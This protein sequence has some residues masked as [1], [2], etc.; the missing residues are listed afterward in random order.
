MKMKKTLALLLAVLMMAAMFAGCSEQPKDDSGNGG[1]GTP[2][3][4]DVQPEGGDTGDAD[5][6]TLTV[7]LSP[8]FAPMEFVDVSKSGQDQ[9]VGFDVMLA[10]YIAQEMGLAL[11]IKA[12]SFDACQSAVQLG[13]VDMSI[14]GFSKTDERAENFLLSDFYYAG[15]NETEQTIIVSADKAG[16]FSTAEDFDGLTVAAQTA[17]LQMDLCN[18]QLPD[19]VTIK[20]YKAIDDAVMALKTGKVDAVA[21]AV[22][23]AEAIISNN[24]DVAMSGFLFEVDEEQQNNVILINK[25]DTELLEQV[26]AILAKAYE[27]GLYGQ[28]YTEAKELAGI[29]TAS[30][31]TYDDDGNVVTDEG[32]AEE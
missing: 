13:S 1:E 16:T 4:G 19:S 10:Q 15:D 8:D 32:D 28:W 29:E 22:G 7:A 18:S 14:S 31:I 12:M 3:T 30:E 5:K 27:A 24:A 25:E 26:N 9:Y 21:V 11:E 23:N 6:G 2:S 17:S 20:E